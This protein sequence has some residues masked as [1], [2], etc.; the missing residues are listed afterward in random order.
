METQRRTVV[1]GLTWQG[2]GLVSMTAIGYI[3]TGSLEAGGAVATTGA[4]VGFASYF[5]HER[6]WWKIGWGMK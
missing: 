6:I 2:I 4:A 5:I 1:K 3:A